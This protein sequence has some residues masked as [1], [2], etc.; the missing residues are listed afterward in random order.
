[1]SDDRHAPNVASGATELDEV[2][3]MAAAAGFVASVDIA[4]PGDVDPASRPRSS[5][6]RSSGAP[7]LRCSSCGTVSPPETFDRVWS[8]RL[9]GASDPADMLHVSALCCPACGDGGVLV[10]NYGPE[11]DGSL[12]R[13]LAPPREDPPST[14]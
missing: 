10:L 8:E 1:M 3:A 5:A 13:L 11:A 6:P 4:T 2:L 9:E 14:G 12:L 7:R